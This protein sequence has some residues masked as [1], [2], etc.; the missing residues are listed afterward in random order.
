M[1]TH[2][3]LLT[4]GE[5]AHWDEYATPA[6]DPD[7][8]GFTAEQDSAAHAARDWLVGASA[9]RSGGSRSP[10]ADGGD[11]QGW[12]H[13]N[14]RERYETLKDEQPQRRQGPPQGD[15]APAGKAAGHRG[16]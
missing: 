1:A 4:E 11:G 10:R 9:R 6:L 8:A 2:Y 7:W 12:D 13:A 14:R 16:R 15:H 5:Q 3:D